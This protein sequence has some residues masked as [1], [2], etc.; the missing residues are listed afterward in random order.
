LLNAGL[1]P[2]SSMWWVATIARRSPWA[3]STSSAQ[4]IT[5]WRSA[6]SVGMY[7]MWITTKS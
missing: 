4:A 6:V 1:V 3:V 5:A 7:S 2:E